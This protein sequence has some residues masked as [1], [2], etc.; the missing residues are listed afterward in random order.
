MD[1]PNEDYMFHMQHMGGHMAH[2]R[3]QTRHHPE[4]R[5]EHHIDHRLGYHM[6]H[7]SGHSPEHHMEHNPGHHIDHMG[8]MEH[9]DHMGHMGHMEHMGLH[10]DDEQQE[11]EIFDDELNKR[12][13]PDKSLLDE[14][15][16]QIIRRCIKKKSKKLYIKNCKCIELPKI[17]YECDFITSI[18]INR[19]NMENICSIP[20]SVTKLDL[21]MN[22]IKVITTDL[23]PE[24]LKIL[25][26]C[27]NEFTYI[28]LGEHKNI[29][30]IDFRYNNFDSIEEFKLPLELSLLD[31]ENTHNIDLK[32]ISN[33]RDMKK[34]A[35]IDLSSTDIYDFDDIPDITKRI[36]A[37]D[38]NNSLLIDR[39]ITK[40]PTNLEQLKCKNSGIS[41]FKFDKFPEQLQKIVAIDNKL[42][43]VPEFSDFT[44]MI[45]F[46]GNHLTDFPKLPLSLVSIDLSKNN[47][48]PERQKEIEDNANKQGVR[49]VTLKSRG[50]AGIPSMSAEM[51]EMR[52]KK[53]RL[54]QKVKH[55]CNYSYETKRENRIKLTESVII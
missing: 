39:I 1:S 35:L 31:F 17:M 32:K 36:S 53:A 48:S 23:I 7:H 12:F 51:R 38:L 21:D 27:R 15:A 37:N 42:K 45:D 5:M 33:L 40:L 55:L 20:E 54:E 50:R 14:K 11:T 22:D 6:E 29:D 2:M 41:E 46:E 10:D 4:H 16:I 8:H 13:I 30:K 9:M 3:S 44:S 34:L 43:T 28:D 24:K 49:R 52:E 25:S 47:I 26:I 19:C 18:T